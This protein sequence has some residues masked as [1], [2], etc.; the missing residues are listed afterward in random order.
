MWAPRQ[1]RDRELE[2][3]Q[4]F[5]GG[6]NQEPHP[7]FSPSPKSTTNLGFAVRTAKPTST[8]TLPVLRGDAEMLRQDRG[9]GSG[10]QE[11][12]RQGTYGQLPPLPVPPQVTPPI[13]LLFFLSPSLT[14]RRGTHGGERQGSGPCL[15]SLMLSPI[16]SYSPLVSIGPIALHSTATSSTLVSKISVSTR[17]EP[18]GVGKPR[19]AFSTV[20]RFGSQILKQKDSISIVFTHLVFQPSWIQS[21]YPRVLWLGEIRFSSHMV[22][23]RLETFICLELK[24]CALS[25]GPFV[26]M[27]YTLLSPLIIK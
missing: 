26:T 5:K 8:Q 17:T 14:P 12:R 4:P 1:K 7:A 15:V 20:S 25:K 13:S 10:E 24:L 21:Q 3:Q 9:V 27:N 19:G 23:K 16:Q 2:Q 6:G 11:S 22:R 18:E